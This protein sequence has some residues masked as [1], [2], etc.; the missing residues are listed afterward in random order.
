[1]KHRKEITYVFIILAFFAIGYVLGTI[2]WLIYIFMNEEQ[3]KNKIADIRDYIM[4][5]Y[6][7]IDQAKS[8]HKEIKKYQEMLDSLKKS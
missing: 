4:S 5:E 2:F 6:C 3:I 7:D 8:L 1:M